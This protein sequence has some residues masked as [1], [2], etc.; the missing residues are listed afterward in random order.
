V[1]IEAATA[2]TW[3]G[4]LQRVSMR[5]WLEPSSEAAAVVA[6]Q[7]GEVVGWTNLR[8]VGSHN[9]R[10]VWL[11]VRHAAWCRAPLDVLWAADLAKLHLELQLE[12]A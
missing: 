8:Y 4:D 11:W 7:D 3:D 1:T 5:T 9:T 6:V 12:G 10:L 2:D